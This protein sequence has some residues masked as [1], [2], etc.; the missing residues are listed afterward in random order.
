MSLFDRARIRRAFSRAAASYD[1]AAELQRRIGEVLLESLVYAKVPPRRILDLGCGTGH[2]TR[3]LK[4]RFPKALVV[5]LDLAE[6]MLAAAR[7]RQGWLRRF[8]LVQ[9]DAGRLPFADGAFD[10]VFSN[11]LLQWSDEPER[12]FA[13]VLRVLAPEGLFLFSTF[14]PET[15]AELREALGPEEAARR[16]SPF[17]SLEWL[18]GKLLELGYDHP[19]LERELIIRR[20]ASFDALRGEL[21]A[22]G[23]GNALSDRPRQIPGKR[24]LRAL[25]ERFEAGRE[26]SGAIPV[27]WEAV[28]GFAFA[29]PA[30]R[31]K[32]M[33]GP[34]EVF[35]PADRIP[36]RRKPD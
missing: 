23:A 21:K 27:R 28:S 4:R 33:S 19:V 5:G 31:S 26:A 14:G 3:A 13:E 10:V 25:R 34:N 16:V 15:L 7:R 9:G 22:L 35:V 20:Y 36:V 30:G 6:G 2:F 12:L 8:R 18:G 29:P 32:R 11:L 24:W 1:Q 17:P